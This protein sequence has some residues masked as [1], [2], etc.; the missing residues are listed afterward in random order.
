MFLICIPS[1]AFVFVKTVYFWGICP[2]HINSDSIFS[3]F[4]WLPI[5]VV[6]IGFWNGFSTYEFQPSTVIV[7]HSYRI[8]CKP[9]I[10]VDIIY[11]DSFWT[12]ELHSVFS[13]ICCT[14]RSWLTIARIDA[15]TKIPIPELESQEIVI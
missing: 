1:L 15:E 8:P 12:A 13:I 6:H 7:S 2:P 9:L 11:F 5:I 10:P 3:V 4:I 14:R